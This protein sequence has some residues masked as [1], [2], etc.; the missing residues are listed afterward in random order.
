MP[1][2]HLVYRPIGS[3][4]GWGS[5][6]V[7]LRPEPRLKGRPMFPIAALADEGHLEMFV[8]VLDYIV[9]ETLRATEAPEEP[10]SPD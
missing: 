5:A 6:V 8:R 7:A 9:D 2:D 3:T 1:R 10:R 4:R